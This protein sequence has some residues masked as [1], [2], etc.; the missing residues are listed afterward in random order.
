MAVWHR[1][2]NDVFGWATASS[3]AEPCLM[4]AGCGPLPLNNNLAQTNVRGNKVFVVGGEVDL[5]YTVQLVVDLVVA[6]AD[7]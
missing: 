6:I 2:Q 7:G 5:C 3:T 1:Y 4:P